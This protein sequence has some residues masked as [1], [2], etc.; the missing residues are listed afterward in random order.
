M[1][2]ISIIGINGSPSD[3]SEAL[4]SRTEKQ[5]AGHFRFIEAHVSNNWHATAE[6]YR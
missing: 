6:L 3:V 4:A 2:T 5:D 1:G